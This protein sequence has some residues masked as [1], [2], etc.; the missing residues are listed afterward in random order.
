MDPSL[1]SALLG[2]VASAKKPNVV[3]VLT[4]QWRAHAF[5]YAG[6]PNVKT[7]EIDKLAAERGIWKNAV[8]V[9]PLCTAHRAALL[10][11]R[12]PTSTEMFINDIYF[13]SEEF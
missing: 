1:L 9:A 3:Y 2:S 7:P 8:S 11:G 4:D 13:P 6:D 12:F 5:G 10:T